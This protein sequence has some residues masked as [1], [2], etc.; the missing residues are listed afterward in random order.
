[1]SNK[2][3]AKNIAEIILDF[4]ADEQNILEFEKWKAKRYENEKAS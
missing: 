3:I 2:E 4:F 1:M